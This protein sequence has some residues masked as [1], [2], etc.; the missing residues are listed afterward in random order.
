MNKNLLSATA[1]LCALGMALAQEN[2]KTDPTLQENAPASTE[3][4]RSLSLADCIQIGLEHNLD[5]KINRFQP[6]LSKYDYSMAY[7]GYD[8]TLTVAYT[9]TDSKNP[10]STETGTTYI[11]TDSEIYNDN[12]TAGLNFL[13]PLGS[14]V[15]I[16]GTYS[17]SGYS[18]GVYNREDSQFNGS[19]R[20]TITQ[21]LLKNMWI[22]STRMN[23]K[24]ARN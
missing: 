19:G 10:S 2:G 4:I 17:R 9:H 20:I 11:T 24:V 5:I 23:I 15:G 12:A 16:Q 6:V 3:T 8:P 14:T 18:S 22:D 1:L 21:P 13:T 7:G